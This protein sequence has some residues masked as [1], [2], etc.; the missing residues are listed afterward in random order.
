MRSKSYLCSTLSPGSPQ[1]EHTAFW[2]RKTSLCVH[3]KAEV[4][5]KGNVM[6]TEDDII[7]NL[8]NGFL[9]RAFNISPF[10]KTAPHHDS[11]CAVNTILIRPI[12]ALTVLEEIR[13]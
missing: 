11:F 12:A 9:A 2:R 3:T 1:L 7:R 8:L 10:K 4:V 5:G 13:H 6:P